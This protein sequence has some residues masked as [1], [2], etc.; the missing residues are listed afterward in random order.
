MK[1]TE[2][3]AVE[4]L[5]KCGWKFVPSHDRKG[6]EGFA[7]VA[8]PDCWV[9][10][11]M[12]L[13][14][15]DTSA[16]A[17]VEAIQ[18]APKFEPVSLRQNWRSGFSPEWGEGLLTLLIFLMCATASAAGLS[19]REVVA[20]VLIAEAG[21]EG[22]NAMQGVMEVIQ[23]RAAARHKAF[24]EVVSVPKHFSSFT[25]EGSKAFRNAKSHPRW[26]AAYVLAGG[27]T[28]HLVGK[29]DHFYSGKK[30]PYWASGMKLVRQIGDLK[31]LES[32]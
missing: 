2:A 15:W 4:L 3:Q 18:A 11:D 6:P 32:K 20:S 12:D 31:F 13:T 5:E 24:L 16:V 26:A 9:H 7:D 17:L 25:G 30:V 19:D 10:E 1:L 14:I 21:G 28:N 23:N 8:V 27:T 29:A 22:T